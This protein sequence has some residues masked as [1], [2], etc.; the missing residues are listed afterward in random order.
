MIHLKNQ[1][2]KFDHST[3]TLKESIALKWNFQRGVGGAGV[4]S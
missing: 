4:Q 1:G 2:G 3:S